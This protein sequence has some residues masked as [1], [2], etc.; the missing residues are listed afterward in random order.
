MFLYEDNEDWVQGMG[1][2]VNVG[3]F[4]YENNNAPKDGEDHFDDDDDEDDDA[5]DHSEHDYSGFSPLMKRLIKARDKLPVITEA[6][7]R[8]IGPRNDDLLSSSST[9]LI[10]TKEA[11]QE[12]DISGNNTQQKGKQHKL[13]SAM[14]KKELIAQAAKN[15]QNRELGTVETTYV[16][17][18]EVLM[19]DGLEVPQKRITPVVPQP[20]EQHHRTS[21]KDLDGKAT[22]TSASMSILA[23]TLASHSSRSSRKLVSSSPQP[24]ATPTSNLPRSR[25]RSRSGYYS[26]NT[27][28]MLSSRLDYNSGSTDFVDTIDDVNDLFGG[29]LVPRQLAPL[30][31]QQGSSF[32]SAGEESTVASIG[33]K[34]KYVSKDGSRDSGDFGM[35]SAR[36]GSVVLPNL[37]PTHSHYALMRS[38]SRRL[39]RS[40][41]RS[42][43]LQHNAYKGPQFN[44]DY[45]PSSVIRS[46]YENN[47]YLGDGSEMK[48]DSSGEY[49]N[50]FSVEEY[51]YLLNQKLTDEK[52]QQEELQL[53]KTVNA[54]NNRVINEKFLR[55]TS[56][57]PLSR[58]QTPNSRFASSRTPRDLTL[59]SPGTGRIAES[60]DENDDDAE[61]EVEV[62]NAAANNNNEEYVFDA[63]DILAPYLPRMQEVKEEE[64]KQFDEQQDMLASL[65]NKMRPTVIHSFTNAYNSN[66]S[67]QLQT[68]MHSAPA[69]RIPLSILH[70][71][72]IEYEDAKKSTTTFVNADASSKTDVMINKALAAGAAAD[73]AKRKQKFQQSM[74][75]ILS[76]HSQ[77]LD[78][79][80]G[81]G[82]GK[83][84]TDGCDDNN[85]NQPMINPNRE[86]FVPQ[87][88]QETIAMMLSR[89]LGGNAFANNSGFG[90]SSR[91]RQAS[92]S[93]VGGGGGGMFSRISSGSDPS[94]SRRSSN[95]VVPAP[96]MSPSGRRESSTSPTPFDSGDKNDTKD[97]ANTSGNVTT[98]VS[99]S[100]TPKTS[101]LLTDIEKSLSRASKLISFT[102]PALRYGV[103]I[104]SKGQQKS[105]LTQ[106]QTT[107]SAPLLNNRATISPQGRHLEIK[108]LQDFYLKEEDEADILREL[109]TEENEEEEEDD[110]QNRHRAHVSSQQTSQQQQATSQYQAGKPYVPVAREQEQLYEDQEYEDDD[111]LDSSERERRHA[112]RNR[113]KKAPNQSYMDYLH[114]QLEAIDLERKPVEPVND[115][116]SVGSSTVA[117]EAGNAYN[118]EGIDEGMDAIDKMF[119]H[120][121]SASLSRFL[122]A[123]MMETGS[124]M[125]DRRK[126]NP[127][128][129]SY[130]Q[131]FSQDNK[132]QSLHKTRITTSSSPPLAASPLL[133]PG[134][135]NNSSSDL[136]RAM[137]NEPTNS[138]ASSGGPVDVLAMA[139]DFIQENAENMTELSGS[140]HSSQ[141]PSPMSSRFSSRRSSSFMYPHGPTGLS[142]RRMSSVSGMAAGGGGGAGGAGLSAGLKPVLR[143]NRS[144]RRNS[145]SSTQSIRAIQLSKSDGNL[146]G[147]SRNS[148]QRG[149]PRDSSVNSVSSNRTIDSEQLYG[150]SI[151]GRDQ[152]MIAD[153]ESQMES[154][155]TITN[156]PRHLE[157]IR[158]A[159]AD[160]NTMPVVFVP[161]PSSYSN[162]TLH[163][164]SH[165]AKHATDV[166][167]NMDQH[168]HQPGLHVGF[169]D[170]NSSILLEEETRARS[171]SRSKSRSRSNSPSD[172]LKDRNELIDSRPNDE[173]ISIPPNDNSLAL[174]DPSG[175]LVT[176]ASSVVALPPIANLRVT[177]STN[178]QPA[179][180]TRVAPVWQR[181]NA[182][183]TTSIDTHREVY[184]PMEHYV[185]QH[186][187][188]DNSNQDDFSVASSR[189]KSFMQTESEPLLSHNRSMVMFNSKFNQVPN[190]SSNSLHDLA[191]TTG[192]PNKASGNYDWSLHSFRAQNSASPAELLALTR[193]MEEK[194]AKGS[195]YQF[196]NRTESARNLLSQRMN[197]RTLTKASASP[198][199]QY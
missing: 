186:G 167:N 76:K 67:K 136:K 151:S 79:D 134:N 125:V 56:T 24:I 85:W 119:R 87:P 73:A 7:G 83:E 146:L 38:R 28:P 34:D 109:M 11:K 54:H 88:S 160:V 104:G 141:I 21:E 110:R 150:A 154:M 14:S 190:S 145:N 93:S 184:T 3:G 42:I 50:A 122:S 189:N 78:D 194:L 172:L 197:S 82:V 163:Q 171:R 35:N 86:S 192:G 105:V 121:S 108:N 198:S 97:N 62:D 80:A 162:I 19:T 4:D 158:T 96:V 81:G 37:D 69:L 13:S 185:L 117:N 12:A 188:E 127:M 89:G 39:S 5:D 143:F 159:N 31:E 58:S 30:L 131:R 196:E 52:Q 47:D 102:L 65:A 170:N 29:S 22:P 133:S 124:I 2:G 84:T 155:V 64:A 116:G 128:P 40:Q 118:T 49:L 179:K 75:H 176:A 142:S 106:K 129:W 33:D 103:T 17:R 191:G 174:M 195:S 199:S 59:I 183:S 48:I 123:A 61:E 74:T 177:L 1:W 149:L 166:P 46:R 77:Y 16:Q 15:R 130:S 6:D 132:Q 153:G 94:N 193:Q 55:S 182:P 70:R 148:S 18:L 178:K 100:A 140:S 107:V 181:S 144:H 68:Q 137:S 175:S 126:P 138:I 25:N 157:A 91:S 92:F 45:S 180:H 63:G 156:S 8:L 120:E 161:A 187:S 43:K 114:E 173:E 135:P 95:N 72:E 111:S 165:S 115:D 90:S 44:V 168:V 99:P 32:D 9:F 36:S 51:K 20:I 112:A 27:T 113:K 66:A 60:K 26:D 10:V 53:L 164:T 41:L 71:D 101:I 139:D 169:V 98:N 23:Q 147:S 152:S 57:D